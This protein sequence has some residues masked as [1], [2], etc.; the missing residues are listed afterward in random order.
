MFRRGFLAGVAGLLGGVIAGGLG[1]LAWQFGQATA[2]WP[3]RGAKRW[4]ALCRLADLAP[5]Q[6]LETSFSF[7]RFEGWYREKVTRQV[8]VVLDEQGAPFVISRTCTHLGCPVKWK[9]QS[10]TFRCACHGGVFDAR[11]EVLEAPPKAPL[12]RLR[13]RIAGELIEVEEA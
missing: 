13:H 1:W 8:Y 7:E 2:R 11:G 3:V 5:G 10:G 12:V 9:A 4:I 6:P